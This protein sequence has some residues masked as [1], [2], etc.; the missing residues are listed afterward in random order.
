MKIF[1]FLLSF[2][3]SFIVQGQQSA[4]LKPIAEWQPLFFLDSVNTGTTPLY[5]DANKIAGINIVQNYFDSAKQ[6]HGKIFITSKDPKSYHFMT[7]P[8]IANNYKR[9]IK[10]PAIFMLDNEFLKDIATFKI[11]SSYI[12]KVEITTA[13]EIEYLKNTFP[14]LTIFKIITRTKENLD[15]QNQ[16]R[17]R[18]TET[19]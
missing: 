14:D 4:R 7:I 6:I 5:F 17:I 11:D 8:E 9:D 18:G 16:V 12:L 15:K 3:V 10:M 19:F 13:A 2:F 1:I